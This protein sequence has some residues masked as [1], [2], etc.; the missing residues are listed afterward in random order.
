[1][2]KGKLQPQDDDSADCWADLIVS[3]LSV[4][5]YSVE[6]AYGLIDG[7][8]SNGLVDPSILVGLDSEQT[9]RRLKRAGYDRGDFMNKLFALRLTGLGAFIGKNG[10]EA[11]T[12]MI[13]NMDRQ[14][15]KGILGSV[16]GVGPAVIRNFFM[17]RGL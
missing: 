3:L 9:L 13:S 6:R 7:L 14:A 10:V 17:L 11:A 2:A 12:Q 8:R 5:N 4:N 16:Y 15:I 1:M